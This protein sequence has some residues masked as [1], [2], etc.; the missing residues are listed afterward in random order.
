MLQEDSPKSLR[1]QEPPHNSPAKPQVA[2]LTPTMWP[3]YSQA[4]YSS[5]PKLNPE[6][7]LLYHLLLGKVLDPV[8]LICISLV[9][10]AKWHT[11]GKWGCVG[12]TPGLEGS[13][14]LNKHGFSSLLQHSLNQDF[15]R[16]ECKQKKI[17][18]CVP[19]TWGQGKLMPQSS[20]RTPRLQ[21]TFQNLQLAP[22]APHF[23]L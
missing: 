1:S 6:F 10:K 16:T 22:T 7:C 11:A 4:I 17:S 14:L 21:W 3:A 23:F 5:H 20:Q 15:L 18:P 8:F 13:E 2:L 9:R 12:K 19:M